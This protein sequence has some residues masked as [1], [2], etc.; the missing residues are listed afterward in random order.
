MSEVETI[1][2]RVF[3][4]GR[5]M[6]GKDTLSFADALNDR[7]FKLACKLVELAISEER[8]ASGWKA[9]ESAPKN[10]RILV[11]NGARVFAAEW[12]INLFTE[13]GAW[14]VA[15]YTDEGDQ[16]ILKDATHWTDYPPLPAAPKDEVNQ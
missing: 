15:T 16:I 4:L 3:R 7:N 14:R 5:V 8:E 10:R 2:Q 11:F 12:A 6:H 9:I 13:E 1:E